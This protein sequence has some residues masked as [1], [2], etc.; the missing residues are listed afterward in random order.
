MD[1]ELLNVVGLDGFEA[2][3]PTTARMTIAECKKVCN[4]CGVAF[5][6]IP[7]TAED[8]EVIEFLEEIYH[9][10]GII[11]DLD[12]ML[13]TSSSNVFPAEGLGA[14]IWARSIFSKYVFSGGFFHSLG[15]AIW[16]LIDG[17]ESISAQAF[18]A[19]ENFG[20][21]V[22]K[23]YIQTINYCLGLA[24]CYALAE[25]GIIRK[26]LIEETRIQINLETREQPGLEK[27]VPM[28]TGHLGTRLFRNDDMSCVGLL[29]HLETYLADV[30]KKLDGKMGIEEEDFDDDWGD[31][32]TV[33]DLQSHL[34]GLFESL[35]E[36]MS[37]NH[38]HVDTLINKLI[39]V[40]QKSFDKEKG[41]D[42][43]KLYSTPG[44][45]DLLDE[46]VMYEGLNALRTV[47]LSQYSEDKD[48]VFHVHCFIHS[49]ISSAAFCR[50]EPDETKS[51]LPFVVVFGVGTKGVDAIPDCFHAEQLV[52]SDVLPETAENTNFFGSETGS[53]ETEIFWDEQVYELAGLCE[54]NP[55]T[56][57]K[58]MYT[59]Q[60][61]ETFDIN[62][63]CTTSLTTIM[64]HTNLELDE[65]VICGSH[66]RIFALAGIIACDKENY[67]KIIID[68]PFHIGVAGKEKYGA[69]FLDDLSSD[70]LSRDLIAE[71]A[72]LDE[73]DSSHVEIFGVLPLIHYENRELLDHT[74]KML[75][76]N[77]VV[78]SHCKDLLE[79]GD[80]VTLDLTTSISL[81]ESCEPEL[82]F[83]ARLFELR[84]NDCSEC[85]TVII[86]NLLLKPD[87]VRRTEKLIHAI[88]GGIGVEIKGKLKP[89]FD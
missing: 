9:P 8:N 3:V 54:I 59:F 77:S 18:Q 33:E 50:N 56:F 5:S 24:S 34:Q 35:S 85:W 68:T 60:E 21:G 81:E 40:C 42:L 88:V 78:F 27:Y 48:F 31:E 39:G 17:A 20:P 70:S 64:F 65:F 46:L 76:I 53:A 73:F 55:D 7:H 12:D 36:K 13:E 30:I 1:K 79:E 2:Q 80:S 57:L 38:N 22:D 25:Y 37:E 11:D 28:L 89:C 10:R 86:P 52:D 71:I 4:F 51:F 16:S 29:D 66:S 32:N 44:L 26:N 23:S 82:P 43:Q 45:S 75:M 62:E 63:T 69:K 58:A 41:V 49:L 6:H 14:A 83:P 47:D 72:K 87:T 84:P 67:K 19:A 15:G 61:E 74:S